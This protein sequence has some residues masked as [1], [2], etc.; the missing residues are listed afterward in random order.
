M[1]KTESSTRGII[2][3]QIILFCLSIMLGFTACKHYPPGLDG[4]SPNGTTTPVDTNSGTQ[5]LI[6]CD[7]DTVYFNNTILPLFVSNCAKAGCHDAI[8]HDE[9]LVLNSYSG[10]MGSG[11][12]SPGN[13]N[14]GDIM[15]VIKETHANKVMPP[16]PNSALTTQQI[17]QLSNWISQGAKNNYCNSCDTTNVTYATKIKPLLDLKCKGCHNAS[18]S[19]G[20]VNLST[21]AAAVGVA[22][23]GTLLGSVKHQAPYKSMPQGG[24][25]LPT[26]EIDM[27][28][29]WINT[30]YPQ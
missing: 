23:A 8:T 12:I 18:L 26:C 4:I 25:K 9:G 22:Q 10:I 27:I 20:G 30:Q 15:E 21:Y 17:N 29:I 5:N 3:Y 7:A 28:S 14:Q 2:Q 1:V 13:P 19:S 11:E 16:P 6:P 24:Q